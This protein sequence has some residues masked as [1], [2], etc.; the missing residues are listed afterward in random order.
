MAEQGLGRRNSSG[1]AQHALPRSTLTALL[2]C[3]VLLSGC[4]FS[5]RVAP[6]PTATP[7]AMAVS[8]VAAPTPTSTATPVPTAIPTET[9]TAAPS[10]PTPDVSATAAAYD[11]TQQWRG[12]AQRIASIDGTLVQL[13]NQFNS[14]GLNLQTG[15][16]QLQGLDGR[17]AQVS[18]SVDALPPLP[19]ADSA[20][21]A[22]YRQSVDQ[23][24]ASVHNLDVAV[25]NDNIFTAPGLANQL[26]GT[27]ADLERQ[28]ADL[29][30]VGPA[31]G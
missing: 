23:W 16:A 13:G 21:L 17:A 7:A 20:S 3:A 5:A 28:S 11:V 12:D 30:L 18:Q 27:A 9:S 24:S 29:H 8:F 31:T 15:A 14:G 19:G 6:L 1:G 4:S 2:L 10:T 22:H 26:E 25:A